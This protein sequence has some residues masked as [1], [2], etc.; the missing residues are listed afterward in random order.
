MKTMK[1]KKI[2]AVI[3]ALMLII[4]ILAGCGPVSD[5][6]IALS[7]S[8]ANP[9]GTSPGADDTATQ[10]DT[11]S[12]ID[13]LIIGTAADLEAPSRLVYNFDVYSGTLL[14]L[15]PVYIDENAEVH[16]LAAEFS[17]EDYK[18]WTLTVIAGLT[19]HDG[20]PVTADDIKFTIEYNALQNTG[21][22]QTTYAEINVIDERTV[23]LV[24]PEPNVRHLSS[25]TTLR[26]VPKHIFENIEDM[27]TAT[28]EQMTLGC[29]PYRFFGYNADA[30]TF[31]FTAYEDFVWGRPNVD[32][33]IF[34][35]FDSVDT[36]NLALKAGEVDM[37]YAYAGGVGAAAAADFATAPNIRL[38]PVKDTSN[39]AVLVFNNNTPPGNDINIRKAV[40]YAIDYDRFHEL[41]GSEYS[42]RSTAGFVPAGSFG[43]IETPVLARD[44]GRSR[45]FLAAAGSTGTDGSGI[46]SYNGAPLTIELMVRSDIPVYERYA[47]LLRANLAEVGIDIT[48]RIADVPTFREIT[49]STYTHQMMTTRFTAFGMAMQAG[50]G[51]AYITGRGAANGQG[52]VMDEAFEEIVT[53]LRTAATPDEYR[54]AAEDCQ[55]YYAENMPAIALFW[56]SHIQAVNTELDG[57]IIDGTFGLLN[58]H[59]WFSIH[60]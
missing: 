3:L 11:L 24:L 34:R 9:G 26:L 30:G 17:S 47:E 46:A 28:V 5:S 23:D 48:F 31:T 10:V 6:E 18:T 1:T 56:D 22:P 43:F 53:R 39:T 13:T 60:K 32:T 19:W 25:L 27:A 4:S 54:A 21:E 12:Y 15:A 2:A 52:Q 40:A 50:M 51:T 8:T 33:V 45:E 44:L 29:G 49:E 16:P 35:M 58:T 36:L 59:T 57:F 20:V 38:I 37:A 41:F 55:H 42:V 14:Q 7:P